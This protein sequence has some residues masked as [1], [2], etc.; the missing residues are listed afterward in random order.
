VIFVIFGKAFYLL[1]SIQTAEMTGEP[2]K[3]E[4]CFAITM[5]RKY[6]HRG[7]AFIKKS[8][9]PDEFRVGYRG[10]Y[11]PRLGK[12][13]LLNEAE[14]LQYIREHTDIPVPKVFC[15]FEDRDAYYLITEYIEGVHM[16]DLGDSQRSVVIEEL[17]SYRMKL[18]SLASNKLGGPSGIVVPPYRVMERTETNDWQL[19]PSVE[20]REYVFCHND[21]S[22]HNIIVDATTLKIKAI[23]DWEYSGFYPSYFDSPFFQRKG[24]SVAMNDEIDDSMELLQFLQSQVGSYP[25]C[26]C[27]CSLLTDMNLKSILKPIVK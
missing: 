12:E 1:L 6:Y 25:I 5:E 10:I 24:P 26:A 16:A 4:G 13:R 17:E 22:Q 19:S 9:R 21:L 3:E 2:L 23:I 27:R 15:H 20:P 7:N 8:L 11:V 14:S 18:K